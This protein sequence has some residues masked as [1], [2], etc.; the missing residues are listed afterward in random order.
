MKRPKALPKSKVTYCKLCKGFGSLDDEPCDDC[1]GSGFVEV[2]SD[3]NAQQ[4]K[5]A[6]NKIRMRK[7]ELR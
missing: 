4:L 6:R 7:N 5:L 2:G 1:D 3:V